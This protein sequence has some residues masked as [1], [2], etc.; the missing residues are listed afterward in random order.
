MGQFN[1]FKSLPVKTK[2]LLGLGIIL[3][4]LVALPLFVWSIINMRFDLREKAQSVTPNIN[5]E[6]EPYLGYDDSPV[7]IVMYSDFQCEFCKS[8]I[9]DTLSTILSTY[10]NEVK[11][12]HKDFPLATIHPLAQ[13]AALAG[14]CAYNQNKFWEMHSLIFENQST[15]EETSF[16][17]FATTLS[18][19]QTLFDSCMQDSLTLDEINADIAEGT[20]LN[21]TGTP[22]FYINDQVI[23][24]AQPFESFKT[25]I[26]Q[27]LL[28]D[29]F[30][31]TT[32]NS[33]SILTSDQ[34]PNV[35]VNPDELING[36]TYQVTVNYS[37]QNNIKYSHATSSAIP[38]TLLVNN[39]LKSSSDIPYSSLANHQDG[40]TESQTALFIASG[41]A[42]N[43]KVVYDPNNILPETNNDNNTLEFNFG[44]T[45]T[46]TP[47]ATATS[48][49]SPSPTPT[50]TPT[51]APGEP[52]SCGGTCG[53]NYNCKANLYCYQGFCRNPICSED[54][55]CDCIMATATPTVKST[56]AS[57]GSTS[58]VVNSKTPTPKSIT[59]AT[60][61][62]TTGMTLI[63]KTDDMERE[64]ERA[65]TEPENMF[66]NKY[67]IYIV[68]ALAIVA[69]SVIIY[70]LKKK[71]TN[72][73]PHIV[74][75]TNI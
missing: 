65:V 48:T 10:P 57:K 23:S 40:Y 56:T 29:V 63:E 58:N 13:T 33:V 31:N 75:P 4:L 60:P 38:A 19:D 50:A 2:R 9:D 20:A 28:D 27:E 64:S 18:L 55:D 5:L 32:G 41:S 52:N 42:T 22:T 3:G 67:A 71:K 70:A 54:T 7:T 62:Y 14:Q 1:N 44:Q 72:N 39:V 12:V 59:K 51:E 49:A 47:T 16:S 68:G 61:N 74:P 73:I 35:S 36:R 53:S 8:F 21:I 11:F 37:L 17:Q 66:V 6:N 25:I 34:N 46:A 24:A 45:A 15:L 30:F 43:I 69:I 26:D